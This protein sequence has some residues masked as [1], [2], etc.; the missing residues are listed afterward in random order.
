LK[1][2]VVLLSQ[3]NR[4]YTGGLPRPIHLRYTGLAEA[5]SWGIWMTYNPY[6]EFHACDDSILPPLTDKGYILAWKM[7]GGMQRHDNK[8]GAICLGWNGATG[9]AEDC[10]QTDWFLLKT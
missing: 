1:I 6:T 2:P 8:P 10:E 7:R 3:L 9:W 4:N 5:V